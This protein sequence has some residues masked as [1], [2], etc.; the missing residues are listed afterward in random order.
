MRILVVEDNDLL[1]DGLVDALR[2]ERETVDWVKDGSSALH[3]L[4]T[5]PFD[6]VILDLGLPKLD[7][8]QVLKQLRE[9]QI[10]VPVLILTARDHLTDRISGLDA[11]AD[12]YMIKPFDIEELLARV[13]ALNRRYHGRS[14]PAIEAGML[15]IIPETRE[16]TYDGA[17][18]ELSR[19]EYALLLELAR[20]QGKVLEKQKL[21]D[22]IYGWG[23]EVESNALEVHIHNLRKKTDTQLIK[24]I[25][26]VG[27]LIP[28]VKPDRTSP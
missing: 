1:G 19:R 17:S 16:V 4:R 3:A 13:R 28:G 2:D 10:Q 8:M 12:D 9:L 24:T 11:G 14:T 20:Y 25:R 15:R 26:G 18:I 21:T 23:E 5:E 7:G 6:L 27:Y 22:L